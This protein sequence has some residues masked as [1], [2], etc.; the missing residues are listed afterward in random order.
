MLRLGGEF[1]SDTGMQ[2]SSFAKGETLE[3]TIKVIE[4][5][6]DIIVIRHPEIGSAAR[7]ARAA[8]I[9]VINAGDGPGE[10]P[11][12]ALLDFYTIKSELKRIENFTISMVGDL[13]YGR[14]VRSLAKLLGIYDNKI[15]VIFVSPKQLKLRD[16]VKK[17]LD[18]LGLNYEETKD[19]KEAI[20]KSDVCY[21]TRI[22][23]ERF[24]N[25]NEYKK[26]KGCYVLDNK[27]MEKAK[28]DMIAMHPLPRVGEIAEEVD[29]DPRARYFEQAE[30]GMYVRMALLATLLGKI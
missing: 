11:T 20:K 13:K 28:K 18:D 25:E 16:D 7:A 2:F 23:K 14:T 17:D 15:K 24:A 21:M 6:S 29:D 3:D 22:Q 26:L 12:Q 4:K 10:H 5:Y 30:N 19:L 1:I 9:P 8:S 27:I